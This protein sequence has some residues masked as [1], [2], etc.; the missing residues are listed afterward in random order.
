MGEPARTPE[1]RHEE[2]GRHLGNRS[3][4]D[5]ARRTGR[6]RGERYLALLVVVRRQRV[7]TSAFTGT[8]FWVMM[9]GWRFGW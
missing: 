5:P 2:T 9:S 6:R 7:Q 8:P 1:G 4:Q 3:D